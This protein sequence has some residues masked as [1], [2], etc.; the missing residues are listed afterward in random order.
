MFADMS[1]IMFS[2]IVS[3]DDVVTTFSSYTERVAAML[4]SLG[5]NAESTG[6]ND[7]LIDGRKVSGNAFY[8]IPGRSIVHG[9][10]LYD[11]DLAHITQAISPSEAKLESKGVDSVR[12]HITTLSRH[13]DMDIEGFKDYAR[14]YMSDGE[15][16]L[17]A[18]DILSIEEM[19]QPYYSD[20]WILGKNPLCGVSRHC[21]IEGVGEFQ[22]DIELKGRRVHKINIAGDYFLLSDID[23][24]LLDRLKGAFYTREALADA[25]GDIDVG[26]IISGLDK[27]QLLNILIE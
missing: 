25:I 7:V 3:S 20:E 15:L 22:V 9:T 26:S 4:R 24:K 6:R 14:R 21:R 23:A 10:M 5:L 2:Y 12:S 17:T 1:N 18:D 19:S 8:H 13:I 27:S 11:T 16:V